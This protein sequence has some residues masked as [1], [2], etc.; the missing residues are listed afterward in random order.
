[1][2]FLGSS[3]SVDASEKYAGVETRRC[4]WYGKRGRRGGSSTS[5]S[6]DDV[7]SEEMGE[8][9][10]GVRGGV[11]RLMLPEGVGNVLPVGLNQSGEWNWPRG[12]SG[13]EGG[14][15]GICG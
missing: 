2:G 10:G 6:S 7:A 12:D 13:G 8:R 9:G 11:A 3:G 14:N 15:D 1:V 4:F 5:P